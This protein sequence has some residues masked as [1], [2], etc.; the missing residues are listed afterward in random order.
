MDGKKE[1]LFKAMKLCL[2]CNSTLLIV[3]HLYIIIWSLLAHF[4]DTLPHLILNCFC[5][6]ILVLELLN[7]LQAPRPEVNWTFPFSPHDQFWP[8]FIWKQNT[9]SPSMEEE[10][11]QY[12]RRRR[13]KLKEWDLFSLSGTFGEEART[14]RPAAKFFRAYL[15][16]SRHSSFFRKIFSQRTK[17]QRNIYICFETLT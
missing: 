2:C 16:T 14:N 3:R 13:R 7:G 1:R 4:K 10:K 11:C 8:S 17:F 12:W 5:W 6:S 15:H 9:F